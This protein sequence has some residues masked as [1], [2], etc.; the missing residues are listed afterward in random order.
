MVPL[1]VPHLP[2]SLTLIHLFDAL[3]ATDLAIS[4]NQVRDSLKAPI[5]TSEAAFTRFATKVPRIVSLFALIAQPH[6]TDVVAYGW[7][8]DNICRGR[9]L[10]VMPA[11]NRFSP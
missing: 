9:S 4:K 1:F 11:D 8:G 10:M 6:F 3:L 5:K 2:L 7:V